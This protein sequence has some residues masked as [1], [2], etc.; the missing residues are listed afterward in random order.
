MLKERQT[1]ISFASTEDKDGFIL[2]ALESI[3]LHHPLVKAPTTEEEY[4]KYIDRLN[5]ESNFGFLIKRFL[6][7]KLASVANISEIVRGCFKVLI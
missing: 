6:D 5:L 1:F 2:A 7:N 4:A 3:N